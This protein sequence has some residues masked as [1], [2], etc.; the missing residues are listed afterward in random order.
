MMTYLLLNILFVIGIVVLFRITPPRLNRK[1]I[2]VAAALFVLTL[3][4]DSLLVYFHIID[5]TQDKILGIHLGLA[6]IEDY[7]YPLLAVLLVPFLWRKFEK[8]HDRDN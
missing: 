3:I 2:L 1:G 4:F 6:P 8:K 7:F 5:Y